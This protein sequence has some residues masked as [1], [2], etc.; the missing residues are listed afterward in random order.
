MQEKN[1]RHQQA[2]AAAKAL[3]VC[4]APYCSNRTTD[5]LQTCFQCRFEGREKVKKWKTQRQ[6]AG[7]C[8]RCGDEPRDGESKTGMAC[9][10]K[11]KRRYQEREVK[12]RGL[13]KHTDL[14]EKDQGED[15]DEDEKMGSDGD[16]DDKISTASDAT[17]KFPLLEDLY[18]FDEQFREMMEEFDNEFIKSCGSSDGSGDDTAS[19]TS[20]AAPNLPSFD[21]PHAPDEPHCFND[22]TDLNEPSGFSEPS[23]FND[24]PG[25]NNPNI[26][27]PSIVSM[28]TY[29][30]EMPSTVGPTDAL[31]TRLAPQVQYH[32]PDATMPLLQPGEE[33]LWD[34]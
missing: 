26:M 4:S 13:L 33:T 5:G 27:S 22:Q 1:R 20:D 17:P 25:F 7:L 14:G 23:S 15:K 16:D 28:L 2:K 8:Q 21:E 9:K 19:T 30:Y 10:E 18:D 31:S 34:I 6:M 12:T 11:E 3:G 29:V 32:D 24:Q